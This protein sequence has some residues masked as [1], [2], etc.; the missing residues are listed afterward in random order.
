MKPLYA[1]PDQVLGIKSAITFTINLT[2]A[3]GSSETLSSISGTDSYGNVRGASVSDSELQF[4]T[5]VINTGTIT[6]RRTG[7]VI[8]VG[9]AIQ[10]R[11]I[12]FE[13]KPGKDYTVTIVV[14]TS[15]SDTLVVMQ[16][17]TA[18]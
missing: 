2:T 13:C 10:I 6:S 5:P 12:G 3:L 9:K 14:G 11:L 15:A 7:E 17:V 1:Y 18:V 4:E 8:A 16:K